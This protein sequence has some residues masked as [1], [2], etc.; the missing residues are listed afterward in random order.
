M[1]TKMCEWCGGEFQPGQGNWGR[2]KTQRYA[3]RPA[4][5][6]GH[7]CSYLNWQVETG[8]LSVQQ[9]ALRRLQK[10]HPDE[11]RELLADEQARRLQAV[12]ENPAT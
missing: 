11:F 9:T 7:P 4:R 12:Q 1:E 8:R 3:S 5:F 2:A 6:C 10:L